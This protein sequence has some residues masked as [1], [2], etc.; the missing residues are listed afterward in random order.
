LHCF[1]VVGFV[2]VGCEIAVISAVVLVGHAIMPQS[3]HGE[4]PMRCGKLAVVAEQ[5]EP[6]VLLAKEERRRTRRT[7]AEAATLKQELTNPPLQ[8]RQKTKRAQAATVEAQQELEEP[9][10]K[11][12]KN[13]QKEG[14]EAPGAASSSQQG[15]S[16][17]ICGDLTNQS[18][19][20]KVG[21]LKSGG[22]VDWA[23]RRADKKKY[24]QERRERDYLAV[25]EKLDEKMAREVYNKELRKKGKLTRKEI[26]KANKAAKKAWEQSQMHEGIVGQPLTTSVRLGGQRL[27][28]EAL[29]KA[30]M[31]KLDPEAVECFLTGLPYMATAEHIMAHFDKIG[32]CTVELIR[33]GATGRPSGKGIARF[34]TAEQA[35]K[36]CTLS[37]TKIQNRWV[38]VRLCQPRDNGKRRDV[39]SSMVKA[40][41]G[42][43]PAGCLTA[44]VNCD[45]SVSE[46][47]LWRFFEDCHVVGVS[48]MMDKQTGEFRGMAFLDFE[49]TSMVDK[50]VKKNGQSVKGYPCSVRYKYDK[51]GRS[52]AVS[53]SEY[54]GGCGRV[55]PHNR[56]PPVPAPAG[57]QTTFDSDS[58]V[59]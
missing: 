47:S 36:A 6:H 32:T 22:R 24:K 50:A 57:V 29:A 19:D 43:K 17:E 14:L 18:N 34:P 46:A 42:E 25:Q 33:D 23:A 21:V 8:T 13:R 9:P 28:A 20:D 59:V 51:G 56:A 35:L 58:D 11:V 15:R 44:V 3:C 2:L 41:P 31:A 4:L 53:T 10:M 12:A 52:S 27:E 1:L 55:A 40:G 45:K 16:R 37:G 39:N 38:N 26:Y 5:H 54:Q 49:D 48:R 30:G 7:Q